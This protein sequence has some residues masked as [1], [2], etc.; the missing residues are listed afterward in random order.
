MIGAIAW[1]VIS[2]IATK[3]T[4]S[5]N[6]TSGYPK[7]ETV[8][9]QTLASLPDK[10]QLTSG[11][12]ITIKEQVTPTIA[13]FY[14]TTLQSYLSDWAIVG[15]EG[16]WMDGRKYGSTISSKNRQGISNFLTI[17]YGPGGCKAHDL[18]WCE[19]DILDYAGYFCVTVPPCRKWPGSCCGTY[20]NCEKDS[21]G[22]FTKYIGCSNTSY[23][24]E[25][26]RTEIKSYS[27]TRQV[28]TDQN[29]GL[30]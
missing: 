4:H 12:Y 14:K 30:Y 25:R 23:Q 11:K 10:K 29:Q 16:G 3:A 5:T 18:P 9:A 24:C 28:C 27:V 13:R 20:G 6:I 8:N 19:P 17:N 26:V 2:G 15:L 1:V 22:R 21:S 7:F